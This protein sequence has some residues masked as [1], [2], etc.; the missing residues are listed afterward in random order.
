[1]IRN[2][3]LFF[4][5][6]HFTVSWII[7]NEL[8]FIMCLFELDKWQQVYHLTLFLYAVYWNWEM[9]EGNKAVD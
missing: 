2:Y 1:M 5:Y 7:D 4:L 3:L 6:T 9:E 8:H